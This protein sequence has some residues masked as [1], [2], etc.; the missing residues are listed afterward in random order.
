[1][2]ISSSAYCSMPSSP[3]ISE[4]HLSIDKYCSWDLVFG[5][6]GIV[7]KWFVW[8]GILW[9]PFE[10]HKAK[11][12]N[13]SQTERGLFHC[14]TLVLEDYIAVLMSRSD[15]TTIFQAH[16]VSIPTNHAIA[17]SILRKLWLS[18]YFRNQLADHS[19]IV[20]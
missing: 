1:M 15:H 11:P 2:Y 5:N 6:K 17:H 9:S 18:S 7:G 3:F 8:L 14:K 19:L 10:G 20:D 4:E 13:F 12:G 16:Y